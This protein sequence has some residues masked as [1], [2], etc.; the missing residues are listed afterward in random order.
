MAP[1]INLFFQQLIDLN[2]REL[3]NQNKN[4]KYSCLLL[5]DEFSAIG[6]I[7]VLA[8]GISYIAGYGLRLLPI[9]QSPNQLVEVYGAEVAQTFTTNH[10][11]NIIFP[12]KAS[13]TK[14][15]SD[16]S[17]W[18]GY[19]TVTGTT[20]TKSRSIFKRS[21]A[22][23]NLQQSEQQRALMLPQEITGLGEGNELIIMENVKPILAKKVVYYKDAVF[24]DRL[25][26]ISKSLKL[27]GGKIPSKEQMDDAIRLGELAAPVPEIDLDEYNKQFNSDE[28]ITVAVPTKKGGASSAI[29]REVTAEDIRNLGNLSAKDFGI[30][31]SDIKKPAPDEMNEDALKAYA[32]ELCRKVG[33]DI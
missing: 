14:T 13:E 3:P 30:D 27:L 15:A 16:I 2:T 11:L 28:P 8:K 23:Q 25:K 4:L 31:F 7:G 29:K 5:M 18:L 33:M 26:G 10:A 20:L 9:I 32:D 12:P 22:D 24:L 21:H 1:L 17:E 6:K 19:T